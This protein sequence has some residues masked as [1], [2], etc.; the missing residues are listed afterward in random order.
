MPTTCTTFWSRMKAGPC[1]RAN[2]RSAYRLDLIE[3]IIA[4]HRQAVA[5]GRLRA[6]GDIIIARFCAPSWQRRCHW[7][8]GARPGRCSK[9]TVKS[10]RGLKIVGRHAQRLFRAIVEKIA[11]Q[12]IGFLRR[13]RG[14]DPGRRS[15]WGR[16]MRRHCRA[17][18]RRRRHQLR[19]EAGRGRQAPIRCA[20]AGPRHR[21]NPGRCGRRADRRS[22]KCRPACPGADRRW[23][24]WTRRRP[25]VRPASK[26]RRIIMNSGISPRAYNTGLKDLR[27][28]CR[29]RLL[30]G[31]I[32]AAQ[33]SYE[34]P[35]TA[36]FGAR[37]WRER[38]FHSRLP[39]IC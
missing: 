3:T 1:S 17:R 31:S 36:Y 2:E 11:E 15:G 18:A 29:R 12:A 20:R 4:P 23:R 38:I 34:G 5:A 27:H 37:F 9:V 6:H 19:L 35:G 32:A 16:G 14:R 8:A 39:W 24:E 21:R 26:M 22:G 25:K 10:P 28:A 13:R 7:R 33:R 30:C